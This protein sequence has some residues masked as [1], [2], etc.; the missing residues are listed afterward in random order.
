MLFVYNN[1]CDKMAKREDPFATST[2]FSIIIFMV[3]V[4]KYIVEATLTAMLGDKDFFSQQLLVTFRQTFF[5]I[6][7]L[8]VQIP[9]RHNFSLDHVET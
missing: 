1:F 2:M 5:A 8:F 9:F 3:V 4:Q 7:I 6:E